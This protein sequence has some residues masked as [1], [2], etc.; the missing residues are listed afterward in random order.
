MTAFDTLGRSRHLLLTTY[1]KTGEA[2]ATPVWVASDDGALVVTT[3]ESGKVKRA[4]HTPRVT[5]SPCSITGSVPKSAVPIAGRVEIVTEPER[6]RRYVAVLRAKYGWQF[7]L[8]FG[9][10]KKPKGRG[11]VLI[12]RITPVD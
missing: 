1:R 4:R 11:A 10:E 7:R 12:L 8:T 5:L 3:V 6:V 9:S 2:V